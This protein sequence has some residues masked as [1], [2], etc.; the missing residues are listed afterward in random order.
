MNETDSRMVRRATVLAAAAVALGSAPA[1]SAPPALSLEERTV[2]AS[3][4]TPGGSV[5][6]F[7]VSRG[8]NGFTGYVLRHDEV[9][10]AGADG[11]ARLELELLPVRSV[12]AVVDLATGEVGLGTPEHIELRQRAVTPEVIDPGGGGLTERRRWVYALWARPLRDGGGGVWGANA[13]DGGAADRDGVE[14][15]VVRAAVSSFVPI[16][17]GESPA[18]ARLEAGDVVVLVDPETLEVA[19]TRLSG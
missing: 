1:W 14:D 9:V 3:G 13:R 18:P 4:V 6:V 7:G 16:G 12:F 17:D 5:A 8:F 11:V 15:S 19:A 2:V 10:T